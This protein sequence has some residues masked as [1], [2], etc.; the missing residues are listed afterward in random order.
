MYAHNTPYY[1]HILTF[2]EQAILNKILNFGRNR[3]T[4]KTRDLVINFGRT[5]KARG[6]IGDIFDCIL[7]YVNVNTMYFDKY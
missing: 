4:K 3:Q 6:V 7:M 2:H 5:H 1:N